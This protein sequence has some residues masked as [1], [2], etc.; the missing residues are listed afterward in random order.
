MHFSEQISPFKISGHLTLRTS[1]F[2]AKS[3]RAYAHTVCNLAL[4]CCT[5]DAGQF[6][7]DETK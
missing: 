5:F 7:G 4:R 3:V 2:P 6:Q 1:Q